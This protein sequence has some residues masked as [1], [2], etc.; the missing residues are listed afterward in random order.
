MKK[1][2]LLLLLLMAS[3]PFALCPTESRE[4]SLA[5]VVSEDSGGIFTLHVD[6][7]PGTGRI[8]TSIDPRTGF[9]TQESEQAAVD[10]AFSRSGINRSEC[11]VFF[12]MRGDFGSNRIDGPSAGGAMSAAV[13]AA[14]SNRTIRRDVVMTGTISPEGSVGEVGGIIE[15]AL[16]AKESGAKY[17]LVPKLMMYESLLLSSVSSE[18]GFAAIEVANFSEA[19]RVLFS[20]YSEN[21]S[22]NYTLQ[23][24]AM[25]SSL[26]SQQYDADT[27]R[28]SIVATHTVDALDDT[29]ASALAH[30][31]A[32]GGMANESEKYFSDELSKY[33]RQIAMGYPFTAANS[34]FLLSVDAEYL[35]MGDS[36]VDINGSIADVQACLDS[37]PVPKKTRENFHW[38]TGAD[39]RRIWAQN[40]LNG[41]IAMRSD[42]EGYSTL[43]DLLY[44]YSWCGISRELA[45][46]ADDIGGTPI[47]ESVLMEL[48]DKRLSEA[49]SALSSSSFL[50]SDA[51][52]H[53]QTGLEAYDEGD[54]GAA[55][56]EATYAKSTQAVADEAGGKNFSAAADALANGTA[57]SLWGKIY[58]GQGAYIYY[59]SKEKLASATD[60]YRLFSYS[61]AL[62]ASSREIDASLANQT[63]LAAGKPLP[64]AAACAKPVII[65]SQQAT[66]SLALFGCVLFL[67]IL[68]FY[69]M[70]RSGIDWRS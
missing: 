69:R 7:K 28:F 63:S 13:N 26:P 58:F 22:S 53:L 61:S 16:A 31:R 41:T 68:V 12:S 6:V 38:A 60:A 40:R 4:I 50:S 52:S 44:S 33:R 48:A 54:Y 67:A 66:A 3:M 45:A 59:A 14:I 9:S 49:D 19:E 21:F 17:M 32:S 20:S 37:L 36:E 34:A 43:R 30:A 15:K 18:G 55:I 24:D 57:T 1:V 47:N 29:V 56:Y 8:Y 42:S 2:P 10:Y 23:S 5:A 65:Y 46:Q 27:A 39:L 62:D 70:G 11:D 25:P 51:F 35:G 64:V